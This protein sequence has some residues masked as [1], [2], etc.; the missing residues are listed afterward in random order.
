[1]TTYEYE[2]STLKVTDEQRQMIQMGLGKIEEVNIL[3]RDTVNERAKDG[4]E[5]L[6][7]FAV[8]DVWF[9]RVKAGKNTVKRR[10]K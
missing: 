6:Y 3:I 8:P 4:W 9:R 7:P 5:P 1:M 2:F 10:K